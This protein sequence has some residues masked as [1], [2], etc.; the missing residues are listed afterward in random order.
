MHVIEI[1]ADDAPA[2]CRHAVP[3]DAPPAWAGLPTTLWRFAAGGRGPTAEKIAKT[4]L[5]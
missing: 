4:D 3:P 5:I 2:F 1:D